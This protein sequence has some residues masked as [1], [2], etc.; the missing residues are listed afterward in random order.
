M[1]SFSKPYIFS[2][3]NVNVMCKDEIRKP[4]NT[5]LLVGV[6]ILFFGAKTKPDFR[7]NFDGINNIT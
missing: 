1:Y 4:R 7:G 5:T 6:N 2:L 3:I